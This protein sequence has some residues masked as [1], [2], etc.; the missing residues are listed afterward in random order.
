MWI[1]TQSLY[2]TREHRDLDPGYTVENFREV[3][4]DVYE[5]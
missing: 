1:F 4:T 5:A 2:P 3:T